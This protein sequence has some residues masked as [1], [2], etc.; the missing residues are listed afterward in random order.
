MLQRLSAIIPLHE[1]NHLWGSQPL[2]LQPTHLQARLQTQRDF[3]M[4]VGQLL[5][6]QL[7]G[8]ERAGEPVT[9]E[10]IL[11]GT[12]EAVLERANH[13]EMPY[14][15]LFRQEKGAPRPLP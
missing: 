5:L 7:E 8:S 11:S 3:R 12:L 13:H 14:L 10:S 2:I 4:R 1:T 6:N 9:L 15:A